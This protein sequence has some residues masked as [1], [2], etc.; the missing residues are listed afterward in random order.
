M[1]PGYTADAQINAYAWKQ[2]GRKRAIQAGLWAGT[3][4]AA[5]A[6]L[7]WGWRRKRGT[8]AAAPPG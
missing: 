5:L 7:I 8:R 4:V 2:Q 6:L 3:I 1:P